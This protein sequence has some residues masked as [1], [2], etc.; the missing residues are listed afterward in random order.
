MSFRGN[1]KVL[2]NISFS[3]AE[4]EFVSILGPNSC[5][6]STLLNIIAGILEHYEG[7]I[8]YSKSNPKRSYAF[9]DP[10]S[11]LLP[12]RDVIGNIMFPFE[13][14]GYSK[15]KSRDLAGRFVSGTLLE[16][17]LNKYAFELSGGLVQLTSIFRSLAYQPDIL[18]MDEPFSNI[19]VNEKMQLI[20]QIMGL[21]QSNR[22]TTIMATHDINDAIF[23]S[24]RIIILT[25][26]PS[27]IRKII[28]VPLQRPRDYNLIS[29]KPFQDIQAEV[30]G[31][32]RENI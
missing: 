8:T 1:E 20:D 29:S 17:H 23:L 25:P 6:K 4:N 15:K 21:W 12:W 24:D 16:S 30:Y 3:V 9:Q 27:T 18:L 10:L 11:V 13:I 26:K 19:G 5:G 31:M 28:D 7:E 14:R 2:D 22:T 32:V